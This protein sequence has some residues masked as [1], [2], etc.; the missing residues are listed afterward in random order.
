MTIDLFHNKIIK[1]NMTD[2]FKSCVYSELL[3]LP[4]DKYGTALLGIQMYE[5][6]LDLG[7][8]VDGEFY[9]PLT[10]VFSD[11]AKREWIKWNTVGK[12]R[13]RDGVPFA[14]LGED[15]IGFAL[16][17]AVPDGFEEKLSDRSYYYEGGLVSVKIDAPVSDKTLL[18]GKYSQTFIDEMAR[19]LT[20]EIENTFAVSGLA[21]SGVELLVVFAPGTYMEHRQDSVTYRRLLISARACAARDLWIKWTRLDG[22]APFTVNDTVSK[23]TI[24]FELGED[25]SQKI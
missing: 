11:G 18:V 5:D 9:Y 22:G 6:C 13:F 15:D 16:C 12:R 23:D 8:T 14:Y 7:F 21:E 10:L 17:E 2:S 3:P 24:K 25:V 20:E 1:D 19:Q 4:V